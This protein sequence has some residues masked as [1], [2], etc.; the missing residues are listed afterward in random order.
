MTQY[1]NRVY[2]LKLC[3]V[4]T[5]QDG[6]GYKTPWQC[7][8]PA[9]HT[10]SQRDRRAAWRDQP[11]PS[12]SR[13]SRYDHHHPDDRN[14]KQYNWCILQLHKT[15]MF[16][17]AALNPDLN[18]ESRSKRSDKIHGAIV[19]VGANLDPLHK[20]HRTVICMVQFSI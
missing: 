13:G 11:A 7:Y 14:H 10:S 4:N 20:W 12:Q 6:E 16:N 3:F 5:N 1:H 18:R 15:T 17:T 2:V 8:L 9:F 19:Y